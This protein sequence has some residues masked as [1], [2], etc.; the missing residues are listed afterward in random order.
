MNKLLKWFLLTVGGLLGLILVAAAVIWVWAGQKMSQKGQL[1][2]RSF[3]IENG[4]IDLEEGERLARLFSCAYGCHGDDMA[5]KVMF[6]QAFFG[7]LVAPNLTMAVQNYSDQELEAIIRQG[8][9]PDGSG[10]MVMPSTQ[11]SGLR[12][13]DLRNILGYI[14]Q[15]PVVEKDLGRTTLSLIARF[16]VVQGEFQMEHELKFNPATPDEG[17]PGSISTGRYLTRV[18]CS[19]C[20]GKDLKGGSMDG[21]ITPDLQ[22]VKAYSPGEFTTLM[23]TGVASGERELDIMKDMVDKHLLVMTD[24]EIADLFQYLQ[25]LEP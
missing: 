8:L 9:R 22:I 10:M 11:F 24:A 4:A 3:S 12:D 6:E 5:G 18:I 19:A 7:K 13:E 17:E 21:M 23:R 16:F 15:A 2:P 20:H 25:Q 14:R 1:E